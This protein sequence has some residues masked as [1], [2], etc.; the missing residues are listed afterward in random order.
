M[1]AVSKI[2]NL[3][4]QLVLEAYDVESARLKEVAEQQK[5]LIRENVSSASQNLAAIS[6]QANASFNQLILQSNEIVSLNNTGIQLSKLTQERAEQGKE[7]IVNQALNMT[8][9]HKTVDDISDDVHVLL[10]ISEQMQEIVSIVTGIADQTN[11]LS[12]NAAIEAARAGEFGQ[13]F[14]IVAGEVRKLSEQT[15]NSVINVS[16]LI[17]NTNKQVEGLT[18]SLEKI[19]AEV[20]A[21]N[22]N[23]LKTEKHFDQ[24]LHT[25]GERMQQNTKI[26]NEL[27]SFV[28]GINELGKAFEEVAFSADSLT[29]ITEEMN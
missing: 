20:N 24:I 19:R 9:I 29:M 27:D 5:V 22:E 4:Q 28:K 26:I 21:G 11:L 3:E 10:K 1:R 13:G 15:K 12:L 8:N 7:Q 25:I 2:L 18:I 17:Q 16:T 23:M 14:A 6:E